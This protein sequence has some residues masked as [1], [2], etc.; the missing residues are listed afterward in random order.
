M[1]VKF[2]SYDGTYPN[3][4]SGTLVMSVDNKEYK[5]GVEENLLP[6]FWTSTGGIAHSDDYSDMW[7]IGGDWALDMDEDD[8]KDY[9][10]EIR[11]IEIFKKM[12]ELM[13]ENIK[14]IPCCG[15]CI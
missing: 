4:C 14:E 6:I 7:A 15:G 12:I 5:F 13:N 10:E 2:V 9:P 3:L 11:D 1:K 8:L